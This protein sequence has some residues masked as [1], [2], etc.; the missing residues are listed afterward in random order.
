[1]AEVFELFRLSLLQ[2]D[3]V[4]LFED[5]EITREQYLRKVFGQEIEFLHYATEF[6]FVP[7]EFSASE[8]VLLGRIGRA[9]VLEDNLSPSEGYIESE[10]PTHRA[11]VLVL[12]PRDHPDGQK[13][14]LQNRVGKPLSLVKALVQRIND[15]HPGS[16]YHIEVEPIFD[17]Q[18]FWRWAAENQ[19]EITSLTFEFVT[20]NGLWS[21][22][23]DLKEELA[24]F[25]KSI[26]AD[27]V[28]TTFKSDDGIK[29]DS[30]KVQE[31][32]EYAEKGSGR[33]KARAR[34]NKRFDSITKR[35]V[36]KLKVRKKS[37]EPLL[38]RAL[39]RVKEILGRE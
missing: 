2:R 1:M 27:V 13:L 18:S 34:N 20:P 39:Q 15:T 23:T 10:Y 9:V 25:H 22:D 19:G 24:V 32:V 11:A 26:G 17:A 16:R 37:K 31:G 30:K 5:R 8:D 3:A 14:A 36:V 29:I 33:I 38:V 4:E 21:A 35:K 28:A 6:H 12:D 7:G